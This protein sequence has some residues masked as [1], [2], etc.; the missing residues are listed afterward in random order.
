VKGDE[1]VPVPVGDRVGVVASSPPVVIIG[2]RCSRKYDGK[3][4]DGRT[5][6]QFQFHDCLSLF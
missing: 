4:S 5:D 2:A 1:H 3:G 6:F